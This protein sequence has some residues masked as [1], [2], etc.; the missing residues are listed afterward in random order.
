[1]SAT[2]RETF[3]QTLLDLRAGIIM[4]EHQAG[5]PVSR[6]LFVSALLCEAS[7]TLLR[8]LVHLDGHPGLLLGPDRTEAPHAGE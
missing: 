3:R 4:A 1:M 8:A 5:R 7:E 6:S 2:Q